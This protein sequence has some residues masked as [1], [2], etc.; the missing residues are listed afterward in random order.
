MV[1]IEK[2]TS[3]DGLYSHINRFMFCDKPITTG[4]SSLKPA[5]DCIVGPV[6]PLFFHKQAKVANL[7][8]EKYDE[9]GKILAGMMFKC[10]LNKSFLKYFP[11]NRSTEKL[12]KFGSRKSLR[13]ISR[14]T[15]HHFR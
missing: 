4:L 15:M 8:L 14:R 6:F 2:Y 12:G 7:I 3:Q 13:Y 10:P 5:N 9:L 1:Y 11:P